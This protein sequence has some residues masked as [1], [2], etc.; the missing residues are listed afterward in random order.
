MMCFAA[1]RV[2]KMRNQIEQQG[3]ELL[4][5][6]GIPLETLTNDDDNDQ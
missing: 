6:E 1:Y 5:E 4:G 3:R 2:R